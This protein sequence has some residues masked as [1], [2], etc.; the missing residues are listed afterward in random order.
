M[1]FKKFCPKCGKE[2]EYLID[3]LC[4]DC[5][6]Q[7]K[8]IFD[9]EKSNISVCKFCNKTK[10]G[11]HWFEVNDELIG[12][13]IANMI[14]PNK[15][16]KQPKIL[17]TLE[18]FLENNYSAVVAVEGF[19][20]DILVKDIKEI[21]FQVKETTCDSCMKINASYRE[22]VVQLRANDKNDREEIFKM[23]LDILKK[24]KSNDSLSDTS[25]I[26]KLKTGY[27]LWVGSKKS[28]IKI[29]SFIAKLYNC[30]IKRSKKLIGQDDNGEQKYRYTFCMKIDEKLKK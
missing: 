27:D 14:K 20:S 26:I 30:Q 1:S 8:S 18:K 7:G 21:K 19:L 9:I 2:T 3:N 22:A 29:S 15:D 23:A 17:V 24:D 16:L 25:K 13:Q 28:A 4:K 10:I 11:N 6:L 12:N 5:Y